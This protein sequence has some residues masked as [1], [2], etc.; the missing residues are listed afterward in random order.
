[1]KRNFKKNHSS[2]KSIFNTL[3]ITIFYKGSA[4][5]KNLKHAT[6][7]TNTLHHI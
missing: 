2:R 5:H 7:L 3:L 6:A 4:N 1:M